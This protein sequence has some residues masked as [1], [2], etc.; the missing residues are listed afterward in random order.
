MNHP[1]SSRHTTHKLTTC[2]SSKSVLLYKCQLGE[3]PTWALTT[4]LKPQHRGCVQSPPSRAVS[5]LG[6]PPPHTSRLR[7]LPNGTPLMAILGRSG[8]IFSPFY[9]SLSPVSIGVSPRSSSEILLR[10]SLLFPFALRAPMCIRGRQCAQQHL[11]SYAVP[12]PN[13]S[14]PR[15]H[16][17]FRLPRFSSSE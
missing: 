7:L 3:P 10:C 15:V 4:K 11:P 5:S 12:L 14:F 9:P 16:P 8:W 13:L 2:C 6:L 1:A 17:F